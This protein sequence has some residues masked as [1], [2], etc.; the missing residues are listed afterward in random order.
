MLA[1]LDELLERFEEVLEAK[2]VDDV[3]VDIVGRAS[4]NP[5]SE[6]VRAA[7]IGEKAKRTDGTG[8]FEGLT[9]RF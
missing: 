3:G 5:A 8:G 1:K 9:K 6:P 2:D 4:M 7:L